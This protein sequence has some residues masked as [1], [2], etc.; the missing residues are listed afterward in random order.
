[1]KVHLNPHAIFETTRSGFIQ[2][3][4]HYSV[5]RE[6]TSLYF[7]SSNLIY[8]GQKEPIEKKLRLLSGW[9]KIYQIP[10]VISETT[11]HLFFKLCITLQCHLLFCTFK[12]K[13]YMIW[14]KAPIKVQNFRSLTVDVKFHQICTL[15]GSFS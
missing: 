2:I 15:I 9:V 6:M 5:S 10:H 14:T 1:M 7:F 4:H 11:G 12:L 3:L 13:F 8:F